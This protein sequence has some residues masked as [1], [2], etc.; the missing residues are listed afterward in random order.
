MDRFFA[1]VNDFLLVVPVMHAELPVFQFHTQ[2][3]LPTLDENREHT[4]SLS[5]LEVLWLQDYNGWIIVLE[6]R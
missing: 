6:I 3:V 1:E 5:L 2:V 4:H